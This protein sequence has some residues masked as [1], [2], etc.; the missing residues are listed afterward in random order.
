MKER[1]SLTDFVSK[2]NNLF[3][4]QEQGRELVAF[5]VTAIGCKHACL[6]F[7]NMH[8]EYFIVLS[9]L[10]KSKANPFRTLRLSRQNP[11]VKYLK[12]EKKL[13]NRE[14][15]TALPDFRRLQERNTLGINLDSIELLAPVI[16]RNRLIGILVL[17]EKRSG[18]YSPED[19]DLLQSVSDR[20]AVGM[21]KEYLRKQL[22]QQKE[23]L[24]V[25]NHS[26]V[27]MASSLDIQRIFDSFIKE[28]RKIAD[29]DWSAI[30]MIKDSDLW[31]LALFSGIGSVWKVGERMPIKGTAA[32]WVAKHKKAIVEPDLS[33]ES[34][35]VTSESHI[36]QGI[37]S[38]AYLPLTTGG[39]T[40]GSLVVASRKPNAY[41]RR[42][43]VLL[44][45]LAS[46]I[47]IPVEHAQ[48]YAQAKD[49]A[50]VDTLTGLFNRRSF[51]E[52]M[53]IETS[54]HSRYGGT[55]SLIIAD[56]DSLKTINDTYGHLA[57]DE[58][59]KQIGN[60][61]RKAIRI[62][63]QAF[64]YGGDEFAILLPNTS[65]AAASKVAERVRKQ[66]ASEMIVNQ[67]M[68]TAS[69]GLAGWPAN[70]KEANEV[71]AAADAALYQAKQ[72]GGNRTQCAANH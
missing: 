3:S 55:F 66:I 7:L 32:E 34:R 65:F 24:S 58:A 26:S 2:I 23:N 1:Q 62:S 29:I 64:R 45:E 52:V 22:G 46:Q 13:L 41:S 70:G 61:I 33:Q 47:A 54:R 38:I 49:E 5:V 68:V 17:G 14:S 11:I 35:F 56:L 9:C 10:P 44:K 36:T 28:L 67:T 8:G 31:L 4:L 16:S 71:I 50:R 63:D 59:L 57:G 21:E 30:V 15:L 60:V 18:E 37:R 69:L 20:A 25:V 40:I 27:I 51:D 48:L 19:Y 53:T 6:L 12:R 43:M 72:S 39:R 42:Q